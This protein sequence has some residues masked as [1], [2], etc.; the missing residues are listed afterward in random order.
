MT[1]PK[2][3]S[4]TQEAD[5]SFRLIG[6]TGPAPG[7]VAYIRPV[8]DRKGGPIGWRLKPLVTMQGSASRIWPTPA[9]ALT[10]TKLLTPGQ[11]RTLIATADRPPSCA[12][13]GQSS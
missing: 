2:T 13:A 12:R 1:T 6:L 8:A 10:S 5:G 4:V 7:P 3:Y 9:E 11:A